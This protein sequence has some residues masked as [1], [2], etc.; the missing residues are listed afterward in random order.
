MNIQ[1]L[2]LKQM[3][4]KFNEILT[5][6]YF[7]PPKS[8]PVDFTPQFALNCSRKLNSLVFSS[9]YEKNY[10]HDKL[11]KFNLVEFNSGCLQILDTSFN[12]WGEQSPI[13]KELQFCPNQI[14]HF[15]FLKLFHF[16]Q[17]WKLKSPPNKL[18][19]QI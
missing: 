11:L 1:K 12:Q 2:T 13:P 19:L 5:T 18:K 8:C 14:I 9:N 7:Q 17:W 16:Q 6:S 4:S 3:S 10:E 15:L